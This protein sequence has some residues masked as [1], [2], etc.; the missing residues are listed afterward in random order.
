MKTENSKLVLG[1][2]AGAAVGAAVAYLC[3]TDKKEKWI[4]NANSL[5]EKAKDSLMEM[6]DSVKCATSK[7]KCNCEATVVKDVVASE[8]VITE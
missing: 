5:L 4:E 1:L 6:A 8:T 2:L 7:A 3:T